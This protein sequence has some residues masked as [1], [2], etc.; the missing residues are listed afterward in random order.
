MRDFCISNMEDALLALKEGNQKFL[1]VKTSCGDV[2]LDIRKSTFVNGQKPFAVV[3]SCSDSRV[4]PESIFSASIGDLFVIRVVGNVVDDT[5]IASMDYAV[6]H[7]NVPLVVVL[8]HTGCGAVNAAISGQ[9][10]GLIKTTIDKISS[11][12]GDE[13]DDYTATRL[14]VNA[15]VTEVKKVLAGNDKVKVVGAVYFGDSGVVEF[16]N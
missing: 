13:K 8:G 1:N 5:V 9:A 16:F 15:G 3:I 14:N 12:I 7:L 2:S 4:I 11:V 10:S 6:S